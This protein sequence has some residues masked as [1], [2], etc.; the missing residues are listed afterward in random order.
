MRDK[1]LY[2][3]GQAFTSASVSAKQLIHQGCNRSEI[4]VRQWSDIGKETRG[5]V[6]IQD[7]WY[8][9]ADTI[10]DSKLGDADADSY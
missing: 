3:A 1:L 2:L 8:R 10:I 4:G 7:L 5:Y 6:M 9:Q